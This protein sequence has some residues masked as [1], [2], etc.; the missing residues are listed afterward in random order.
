MKLKR[1]YGLFQLSLA[2]PFSLLIRFSGVRQKARDVLTVVEAM[3]GHKVVHLHVHRTSH[4]TRHKS[5]VTLHTFFAQA[6][7]AL[8]E[9][10]VQ[11]ADYDERQVNIPAKFPAL[12]ES[13]R[14]LCFFGSGAMTDLILALRHDE[15]ALQL[16]GFFGALYRAVLAAGE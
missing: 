2:Y 13:G 5:H 6:E 9:V 15:I 16:R 4:A 12:H 11:F 7:G 3:D 10:G 1:V 14:S 8:P